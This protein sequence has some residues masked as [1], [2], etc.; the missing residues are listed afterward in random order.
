[1][2]ENLSNLLMITELQ[3]TGFEV[4]WLQSLPSFFLTTCFTTDQ[5]WEVSGTQSSKFSIFFIII[6][7][8]PIVFRSPIEEVRNSGGIKT[9]ATLLQYS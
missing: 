6:I 1:M 9:I 5:D 8:L 3:S 2:S 7:I 4:C